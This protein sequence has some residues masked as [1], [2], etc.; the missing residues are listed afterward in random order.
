MKKYALIITFLASVASAEAVSGKF[1]T[2]LSDSFYNL[3]ASVW[4]KTEGVRGTAAGIAKAHPKISLGLG[5]AAAIYA[6]YKLGAFGRVSAASD[7][8]AKKAIEHKKIATGVVLTSGV[9]LW[10]LS[11][12]AGYAPFASLLKLFK[13]N[14]VEEV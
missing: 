3:N 2:S 12:K 10:L 11:R 7:W 9:A 4:T 8:V 14:V 13:S 1:V 5:Y 6:G